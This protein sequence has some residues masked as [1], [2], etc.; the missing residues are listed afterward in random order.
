MI[1]M[2]YFFENINKLLK[3]LFYKDFVIHDINK[4][5]QRKL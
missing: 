5:T 3:K 1:Q 4:E 2:F